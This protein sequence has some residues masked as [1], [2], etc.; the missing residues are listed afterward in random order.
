MGLRLMRWVC[1]GALLVGLATLPLSVRAEAG[2]PPGDGSG[3]VPNAPCYHTFAGLAAEAEALVQTYPELASWYAIGTS[4]EGRP[5]L[6]LELTRY[7][8]P[9]PKPFLFVVA[10]AHGREFITPEVALAFARV[11]LEGYGTDADATWVLETQRIYIL[12]SLNPD[13]HVRNES[14]PPWPHWR[15]NMNPANGCTSTFGVDLNRNFAVGWGVASGSSS[16][17]CASFYR[18]PEPFSE[19]ETRAL[20]DYWHSLMGASGVLT[21]TAGAGVYISLHAYGNGVLWPWA[22]TGRAAPDAASL[23]A[24]GYRLARAMGYWGGQAANSLYLMSG[25]DIDW[26]YGT[27]G[28]PAYTFEVGS[29]SYGFFPPCTAHE[30]IITAALRG[31]WLA[32]R[33]ARAPYAWAQGPEVTDVRVGM[34]RGAWVLRARL[35][36]RQL[37]ARRV[38]AA[39]FYVDTPPWEGGTARPLFVADGRW[40]RFQED[41]LAP[42]TL[43]LEPGRHVL[44][45]QGQDEGGHWGPPRAVFLTV[46]P[47]PSALR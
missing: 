40:D 26:V 29:G 1:V 3:R 22:Y 36:G 4:Y 7:D 23:S 27:Y 13:G 43:E 8:T 31:L 42:L 5:L 37:T 10:N 38:T 39:R 41:V 16:A 19:P 46:P 47:L 6:M 15:K 17:P 11:L 33:L 14:G 18:G 35:D 12:L 25:A 24:L 32:A 9:A 2:A 44:Y 45:V 28:V 21:A 20:R 34:E 30:A